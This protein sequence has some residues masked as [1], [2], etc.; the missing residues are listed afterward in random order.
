MLVVI[1]STKEVGRWLSGC[2]WYDGKIIIHELSL[3]YHDSWYYYPLPSAMGT[4]E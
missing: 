4:V 1:P 3:K 2:E